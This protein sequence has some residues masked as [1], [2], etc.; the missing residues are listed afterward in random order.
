[1]WYSSVTVEIF[2]FYFNTRWEACSYDPANQTEFIRDYLGPTLN[3]TF[4]DKVKIMYMDYTKDHLME[5]S[6]VVLQ[7]SK[8]AQ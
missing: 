8:A 4:G 7:D 1:M 6:D 5:V 2:R 3:K